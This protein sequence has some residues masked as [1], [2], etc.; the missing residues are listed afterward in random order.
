MVYYYDD[1]YG[2]GNMAIQVHPDTAY[3]KKHF[4]EPMRQDESYYILH[5]GS[6]AKT[7]LGL[8]EDTNVDEFRQACIKAEK[9]GVPFDYEKYV[10]GIPTK[11]GDYLLIP[12]GTIHASGRNQVVLEI[13]GYIGAYGPGYT[14]HFYDYLR[15]DLDGALRAI[16]L[17][18]S[19]SMLRKTRRAK[20]VAKHLKQKPRL[21]RADKDWAEYIIG[22]R[23]DMFYKVHRLEFKKR[24]E[25]DTKGKFHVLTLV[26]G[27]SIIVQSQEH[28]ERKFAIKFTETLIVPACLGKYTIKN[29]GSKPCKVTKALLRWN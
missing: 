15:P 1:G 18:H 23:K 22:E 21:I 8:N 11:P 7:Y 25:D 27:D 28:S 12:A 19:F 24:I 6:G 5:T 26:E 29:L 9:E 20:W 4:N 17:E 3:I 14:F 10:N 16:H 2:G 13:D